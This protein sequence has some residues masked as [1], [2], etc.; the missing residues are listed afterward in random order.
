V[1]APGGLRRQLLASMALQGSGAA[2]LLLATLWLG[3]TLGPG[4]QGAF[5]H[6]K[7][8]IEFVAA[9]AMFGLP[10]ALFFYLQSGRL[11]AAAARRWA[12]ASALLALPLGVLFVVLWPGTGEA[13]LAGAAAAA[14]VLAVAAMVLHGQLR[15]QLLALPGPGWF[16]ALTALP[17][18]LLLLGVLLLGAQG[19]SGLLPW[20]LL[21]AL[22]YG[23]AAVL[24][25]WRLRQ[26]PATPVVQPVRASELLHYG[27]AAW[28][29]A[30]LATAALLGMQRLVQV[31][32]GAAALGQFTLAATLAQVPLTPVAYAAPL[33][34]RRWMQQADASAAWP[35]ARVTGALLLLLALAAVG[36][37]LRWPDLGLGAGYDG[38]AW[39]LVLMLLAAAAESVLRLLAV[40]AGAGGL[41]WRAVRAEATRAAVLLL[42]ALVWIGSGM[43]SGPRAAAA[44]WLLA[45]V[46]AMAVFLAEARP[47]QRASM[48]TSPAADGPL[49]VALLGPANSIHLQRWAQAIAARGHALCVISQHRCDR[50]LLPAA[51]ACVWLPHGGLLG[52]F[53]NAPRLR[54][55]LRDWRPDLLHAH[56]ASGYG[57]TARLAG[58]RPTL[59][60]VWGSDVDEFPKRSALHAAWLRGNLRA[61]TALAATS[62]AMARQLQQW[63]PD[64]APAAVTPFGVDLQQFRPREG[65]APER[66]LT[67]GIVKSLAPTYGVDLLLR[68]FAGLCADAPV[69]AAQPGLRL[70]IVGDGPQRAELQALAASLGI[71]GRVSFA[72]ATAHVQVPQCLQRMDVFVAPSRAESFGV[73]V[74]E[75]GACG[76]PAVVSAAGGLPEVVID[77]QTGLVVPVDDVAALQAALRRL[78]LEDALR[79]RMGAAARAH[80]AAVYDWERCVD[81]MLACYLAL[82]RAA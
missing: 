32:A 54:R 10:Q 47:W 39:V 81:R 17:P 11:R 29:T 30:V 20:A 57:S 38:V 51:A 42:G 45:T 1:S 58:F 4:P 36:V 49:R 25:V 14:L 71:D 67:L 59:L 76:L 12:A 21:F 73:A 68:A 53:L 43:Q 79:A 74:V 23:A 48:T 24:A 26:R 61:A 5:S 22:A 80:V 72:G 8:Q 40:Q 34:L 75:A 44:L 35:A 6:L 63:V 2:A 9:L 3:A 65:P 56:Y 66:G 27:T 46:A 69:Q 19:A 41:P 37:A 18:V 82:S 28:L 78:V 64:C 55:A 16:N 33:L 13:S 70:L 60:S 31:Q 15:T 7:S 62:P 52:Y 77:G 50:A